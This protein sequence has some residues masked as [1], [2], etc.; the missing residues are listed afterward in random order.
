MVKNV[1][2]KKIAKKTTKIG[3]AEIKPQEIKL[4]TPEELDAMGA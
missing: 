2:A 4:R 3:S 1:K